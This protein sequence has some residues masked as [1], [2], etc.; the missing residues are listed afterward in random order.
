MIDLIS[1]FIAPLEKSGLRY[2]VTGSVATMAYGEPRLTND[3]DLIL[4]IN[5]TQL[6]KLSEAFPEENFYLPPRE[7][8][9]AECVR[10]QRGHFN[11]ISLHSMLKADVYLC[12]NDALHKWAIGRPV[13]VAV[14]DVEVSFAPIEY[15]ILRK[16]E[17]F[18]EG[19]SEKHLRDI[20]NLLE[21]DSSITTNAFLQEQMQTRNFTAIWQKILS[22]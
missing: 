12:G 17:F 1:T 11:I 2:L 8:M 10:S 20:A 19:G 6:Q 7:V 14:A 15:V 22:L 18:Q 16:I 21:H 4:E 5:R 9:E 3:I 13:R